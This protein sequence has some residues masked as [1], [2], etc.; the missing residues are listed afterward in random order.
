MLTVLQFA[1][2]RRLFRARE[3][4]R[5]PDWGDMGTAFGLDQSLDAAA[6]DKPAANEA[7]VNAAPPSTRFTWRL[8]PGRKLGT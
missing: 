7:P 8:W 6:C 3:R 1:F 5:E 2:L 4:L